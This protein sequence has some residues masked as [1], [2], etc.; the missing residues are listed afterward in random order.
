MKYLIIIAVALFILYSIK[1]N[2]QTKSDAANILLGLP[3]Q[4]KLS[5]LISESNPNNPIVIRLSL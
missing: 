5:D 1:L 2:I 4:I 3:I